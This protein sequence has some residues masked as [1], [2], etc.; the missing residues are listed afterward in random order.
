MKKT[1]VVFIINQLDA[2]DTED[3]E[4]FREREFKRMCK[5][6]SKKNANCRAK[7]KHH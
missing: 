7:K 6:K 1:K 5:Q 4:R 3:M 2:F